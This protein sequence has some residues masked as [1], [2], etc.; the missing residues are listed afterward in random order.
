[1]R[2]SLTVFNYSGQMGETLMQVDGV[3]NLH[4]LHIWT[5]TSGLNSLSY[6]LLAVISFFCSWLSLLFE[7]RFL[8]RF[9]IMLAV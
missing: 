7:H 5:I 9:R 8:M 1:M 2:I 4:D 3:V 6:H